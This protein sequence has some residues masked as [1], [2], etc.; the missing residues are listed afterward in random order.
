MR[1]IKFRAWDKKKKKWIK[2]IDAL[3]LC[4]IQDINHNESELADTSRYSDSWHEYLPS[5]HEISQY[6]GLK[7]KNGKEI[8]EGDIVRRP[9]GALGFVKYSA[10]EYCGFGLNFPGY[11]DPKDEMEIPETFGFIFPK[12]ELGEVIGNIYENPELV[13]NG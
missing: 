6:T 4:I 5:D 1:E 7:D 8:Y 11:I 10:G 3:W 2:P 13:K 12:L 9:T